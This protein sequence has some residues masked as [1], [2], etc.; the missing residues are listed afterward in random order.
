MLSA[1]PAHHWVRYQLKTGELINDITIDSFVTARIGIAYN[2][3]RI[4]GGIGF[5]TRSSVVKIADA[6]FSNSNGSFKI[7]MGY[8]FREKGFLTR[9]AWDLLPF[10]L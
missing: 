2:G 1:G 4:F 5:V 3:D 6:E 10:H 8:R 7:L 9:R